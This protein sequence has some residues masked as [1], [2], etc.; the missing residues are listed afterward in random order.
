MRR[1]RITIEKVQA[2]NPCDRY[3]TRH[4]KKL[5]CGRKYIT[6]RGIAALDISWV[7]KLWLLRRLMTERQQHIF[8]CDCAERVLLIADD[9]RCDQA[10]AVKRKWIE[11]NSTDEELCAAGDAA[12]S[13]RSASL[14]AAAAFF[15]F[16]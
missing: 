11:G 12:R 8:N 2:L 15:I 16:L 13:A 14:R 4:L 10:I 6:Y 5:L 3:T 1:G 9:E 7:A